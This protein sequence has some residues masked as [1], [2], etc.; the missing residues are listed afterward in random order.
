MPMFIYKKDK[1]LD[2]SFINLYDKGKWKLKITYAVLALLFLVSLLSPP[3]GDYLLAIQEGHRLK[4]IDNLYDYTVPLL[5]AFII[6]YVF[7]NDYQEGI[8]DIL[9]FYT[10]RTFNFIMLRRWLTYIVPLSLGSLFIGMIYFRNVS[11]LDLDSLWLSVRF[12]PNILFLSSLLLCVTV[13]AKNSYTGLF[14]TLVYFIIDV[15]SDGRI[16]KLFSI[17]SN[18][19]NFFYSVSPEYYY[20]NRLMILSLSFLF[21]FLSCKRSVKL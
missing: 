20:L 7:F 9:T 2:S 18:T 8:H 6:C 10:N 12:T 17:G 21:L 5:A 11:F 14:V 3:P 19:N 4:G 1:T 16:F 13:Y 15:L